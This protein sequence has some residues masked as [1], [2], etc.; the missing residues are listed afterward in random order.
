MAP[1]SSTMSSMATMVVIGGA[2]NKSRYE[3]CLFRS[4]KFAPK[5]LIARKN[6]EWR[7]LAFSSELDAS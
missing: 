7:A 3:K 1:S 5:A 2:R 6:T 4:L